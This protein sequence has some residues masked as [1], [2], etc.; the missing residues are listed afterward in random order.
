MQGNSKV[1]QKQAR[2]DLYLN[3]RIEHKYLFTNDCDNHSCCR[4]HSQAYD[5]L[6]RAWKACERADLRAY[7]KVLQDTK[8]RWA[9]I[10]AEATKRI[11]QLELELEEEKD[12]KLLY[13]LST[14]EM[15]R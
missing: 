10:H 11:H 8:A 3:Y 1:T 5:L 15:R 9:L 6:G 7:K 2:V 4:V 14:V 12:H 13:K